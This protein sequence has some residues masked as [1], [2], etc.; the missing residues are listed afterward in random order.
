[1][2]EY[3]NKKNFTISIFCL[4][5]LTLS[6]LLFTQNSFAFDE[7]NCL[8]CHKYRGLSYIDEDNKF[9]LL[10]ITEPTYLNS[11]HALSK[12]GDCHGDLEG[13]PHEK[14]KE[15]DC[16]VECHVREPFSEQLFS[17][18]KSSDFLNQS[19]HAKKDSEGNFK[20]YQ[21]DMPDCKDCHNDPLYRPF[22]YFKSAHAGISKRVLGRCLVC[23]DDEIYVKKFY[24]HF[25]SRM[26][27]LRP[28]N[29]LVD[30]CGKCHGDEE[31]MHRH[32]LPNAIHSYRETY[33][34]KAVFFGDE[35]TPDCLDCHVKPGE[36]VHSMHSKDDPQ[37][38]VH[39]SERSNTCSTLDCH[40][41]ADPKLAE[42]N[43]HAAPD[44]E[45]NPVVF[46]VAVFF[47][48]LTTGTF[49]YLML[50]T[51]LDIARRLFP[52]AALFPEKS[53]DEQS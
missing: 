39:E 46:F 30:M 5:L 33:H 8:I 11:P 35:W 6:M 4:L 53:K 17:H 44:L 50:M 21:E 15:V 18:Q 29:E 13:F 16:L 20:E 10:Y 19:V 37:S 51:V 38:S 14:V 9:R 24:S 3:K 48:I 26:Q 41:G 28:P 45:R 32:N 36:S 52:H 2:I 49:A 23:H 22:Y 7:Q 31:I 27:K 25:S 34:G 12:C 42:Y 40:P 43:P 1:M 47:F